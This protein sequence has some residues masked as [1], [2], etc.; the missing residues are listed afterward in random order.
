MFFSWKI[1]DD[2]N[3][4][5]QQIKVMRNHG[6]DFPSSTKV[7]LMRDAGVKWPKKHGF[8]YTDARFEHWLREYQYQKKK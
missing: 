2:N 7:F 3:P 8:E 6:F 4:V 1:E 5:R